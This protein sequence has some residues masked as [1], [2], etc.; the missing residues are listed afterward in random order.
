MDIHIYPRYSMKVNLHQYKT[1]ETKLTERGDIHTPCV[2]ST[3]KYTNNICPAPHICKSAFAM[4][5]SV[6]QY[7]QKMKRDRNAV[8]YYQLRACHD[9]HMFRNM[10][11]PG[12]HQKKRSANRPLERTH[13]NIKES[14]RCVLS[15]S[16]CHIN[17]KQAHDTSDQGAS[18]ARNEEKARH[19]T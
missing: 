5:S 7:P 17:H 14:Q 15:L 4:F 6:G 13:K 16:A 19:I 12:A 3:H 10:S 2:C 1:H 8:S 11:A 9:T 18:K